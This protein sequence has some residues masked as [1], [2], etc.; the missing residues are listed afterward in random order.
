MSFNHTAMREWTEFLV[1]K[2]KELVR[3]ELVKACALEEVLRIEN[4]L[5]KA[6]ARYPYGIVPE[7]P[8]DEPQGQD[9][10]ESGHGISGSGLTPL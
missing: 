2:R 7:P 9:S 10:N 4:E 1:E 6:V 5:N 8:E 3:A